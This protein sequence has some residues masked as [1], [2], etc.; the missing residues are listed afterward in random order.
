MR[1]HPTDGVVRRLARVHDDE[2]RGFARRS[3]ARALLDELTALPYGP[4][5]HPAREHRRTVRKKMVTA[6]VAAVAV[7]AATVVGVIALNVHSGK[8]NVNRNPIQLAAAVKITRKTTY[9]EARIV[10][11]LADKKRFASAFAKYG[12]TIEVTLLPASPHI[13]GT[14]VFEDYDERAQRSQKEGAGI[15]TIDDPG[16]RTASGANCSIGLRI[17]LN[18]KGH[19]GIAIGRK[20]RPGEPYTT[21]SPKDAPADLKGLTVT[22]A[23][24]AL[25]RKG[26]RVG[27]Y[28]VYWPGW[29]TSLPRTRIPSRW[30]VGGADPYSPG[31]VLLAIDAQGPMPPDVVAEMRR[32]ATASPTVTPTPTRT[33]SP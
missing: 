7:A 17:P 4:A 22:Q 23:E 10:D 13:V 9:Y 25:A 15:K 31:T 12:L 21:T 18:F 5:A 2:L 26:L 30:K 8:P 20:A 11:P 29:G 14:I 33:S 19:V 24:A 32:E 3:A 27:M 16:C 1:T 28:N 6:A